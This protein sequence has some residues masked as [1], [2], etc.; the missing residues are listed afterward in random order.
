MQFAR[1]CISD[2]MREEVRNAEGG[3]RG[4]RERE[5]LRKAMRVRGEEGEVEGAGKRASERVSEWSV[6]TLA[7]CLSGAEPL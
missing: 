3:R 6:L 7:G 5:V 1:Y 2:L 4:R